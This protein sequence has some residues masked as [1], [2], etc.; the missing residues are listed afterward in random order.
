MEEK[1]EQLRKARQFCS[2]VRLLAQKYNLPFFVVTEGASATNN[3]GC[4][5]VKRARNH[6]IEWEK[7][8]NLNLD[9]DWLE[10]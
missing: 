2:E 6:H 9:E 4:E 3:D 7:E 10:T 5:A 1:E 8:Q